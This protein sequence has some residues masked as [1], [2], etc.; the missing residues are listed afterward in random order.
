MSPIEEWEFCA[1]YLTL[2]DPKAPQRRHNLRA[3]FNGLRYMAK[4]GV[5]WRYLPANF[6]PY[7]AVYQQAQ[8]WIRAGVLEHIAADLRKLAADAAR[9]GQCAQRGDPRWT[10]LAVGSREWQPARATTATNA[11]RA[12]KPMWLWTP[13]AI[14]WPWRS[15][16]PT[17]RSEPRSAS[18]ASRFR[19]RPSRT[20][21][22]PLSIRDTPAQTLPSRPRTHDID[23][24]VV[25]LDGSQK[26]LR[27]SATPMGRR[28]HLCLVGSLPPFGPGL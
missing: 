2:M 16:Q 28:T 8:R 3:L 27:P 24:V 7:H 22:S 6:P 11:R 12:P 1:P 26:G 25:Q 19:K 5:Q 9:S 15:P 20:C 14:S 21:R 4:T 23:L 13:W 18:C 10:H 17:N